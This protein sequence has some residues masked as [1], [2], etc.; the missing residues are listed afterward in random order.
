MY[1]G[2]VSFFA[3]EMNHMSGKG[4]ERPQ[5]LEGMGRWGTLRPPFLF[6]D[7]VIDRNVAFFHF[8]LFSTY[9]CFFGT[10]PLFYFVL[11]LLLLP[12]D[13]VCAATFCLVCDVDAGF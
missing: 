11:P 13:D 3:N 4:R 7:F 2:G 9:H 5:S 10:H 8:V 12:F 1:A 6:G